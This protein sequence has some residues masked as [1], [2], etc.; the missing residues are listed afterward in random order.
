MSLLTTLAIRETEIQQVVA[1]VQGTIEGKSEALL[2]SGVY[3][4]YKRIHQAY[5]QLIP[6]DSTQEALKR[7]LFIQWFSLCEPAIYSGINEIDG[8][9]ELTVLT[10]LD[11]LLSAGQADAELTCMLRYYATWE[12][13]FQRPEFRHLLVLQAFVESTTSANGFPTALPIQLAIMAERG[14]MGA[15]WLI[16]GS[17]K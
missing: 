1:L 12:Y 8:H 16:W 14:Q 11:Q 17:S 3:D 10:W 15:Y 2:K 9:A 4:E 7:A 13:V 6:L 5:S